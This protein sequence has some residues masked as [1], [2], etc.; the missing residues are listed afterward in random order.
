MGRSIKGPHYPEHE[1]L[2]AVAETSQQIGNF[3]NW[4]EEEKGY[5]LC[6]YRERQEESHQIF[7]AQ[8]RPVSI[9]MNSILAEYFDIDL[10]RL[11]DEKRQILELLR[12][13]VDG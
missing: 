10:A 9:N 8:Y 2:K 13:V 6:E 11:E 1:K 7:P 3:L 12:E 5:V 4:L